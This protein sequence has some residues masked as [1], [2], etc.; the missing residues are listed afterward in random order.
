MH[1]TPSTLLEKNTKK[2][3]NRIPNLVGNICY[4]KERFQ[5]LVAV[6]RPH[7]FGFVQNATICNVE[8]TTSSTFI[9]VIFKRQTHVCFMNEV[10]ICYYLHFKQVFYQYGIP[11]LFSYSALDINITGTTKHTGVTAVALQTFL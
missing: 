2:N 4:P 7:F 1:Q 3:T 9:Y 11:D 10:E 5:L 6:R 8:P